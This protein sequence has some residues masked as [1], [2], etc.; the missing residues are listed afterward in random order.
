MAFGGWFGQQAAKAEDKLKGTVSDIGSTV[1]DVFIKPAVDVVQ[2]VGDLAQNTFDT[3][4]G[5]TEQLL[6]GDLGGA[7]DELKT[8]LSGIEDIVSETYMDIRDPL[9]A[10]AVMIGNYFLPGSS[11]ITSKLVSDEAQT[12]LNTNGGQLVNLAAGVGG[13]IQGN[14]SNYGNIA[15][16]TTGTP[17]LLGEAGGNTFQLGTPSE[18]VIPLGEAA[19]T[20]TAD[21]LASQTEKLLAPVRDSVPPVPSERFALEKMASATTDPIGAINAAKGYSTSDLAYL[22]EIGVPDSIIAN[23]P[24]TSAEV[25]S[26][27][28]PTA[29]AATTATSMSDKLVKGKVAGDAIAKIAS[30]AGTPTDGGGSNVAEMSALI[31]LLLARRKESEAT[32]QDPYSQVRMAAGGAVPE[33]TNT[34]TV[35]SNSAGYAVAAAPDTTGIVAPTDGVSTQATTSTTDT[36]AAGLTAKAT[37]AGATTDAVRAVD[38]AATQAAAPSAVTAGTIAASTAQG[39]VTKSLE[40]VAAEQGTVSEAAKI[41]AQTMEPTSTA[42]GNLVAAQGTAAQVAPVASRTL[43]AGELVS[44]TA[45]DQAKIDAALKQN[46]AAQGTVTEDMTTQGQLNKILTNFDAGNP[47]PWA[48]AS[49]R[50]ATA[51]MA[52]RGLGASSLAGQAII[53]ATLEAATPIAAADAKV[54]EQMGLTNLSN[55]QQ[56]AVLTGQQ[57]AA[58]L[59]QEFD[60]N[61][62]T[63]VLNAARIA[64]IADK[65]FTATVQIAL[66]N[67]QLANTMNVANLSAKNALVLAEAAQIANLE[68]TN[69]NNRQQAAVENAKSFLAMDIKNLDN[70]QQ[71]KLFKAKEIAD[72]IVSD[73]A[74]ENAA[75]ATNAANKLDA[76]KI[77]AN[78]AL[79]ASTFNAAE[80]N[81]VAITNQSAADA[82]L[83]F[84]AQEKNDRAEFNA[85]LSTQI[86]MANAK[87]LADISMSNTREQNAIAQVNA[88]NATDMSATVF[89]QKT[90]TYRDQMELAYKRSDD[91]A[92]RANEIIKQVIVS[93]ASI[94]SANQTAD[95]AFYGAIGNALTKMATG[96]GGVTGL[97]DDFKK[98]W[99]AVKGLVD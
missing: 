63:K 96:S 82:M 83:K 44:G 71:T 97:I 11:I 91:N 28:T 77:N 85:N 25:I 94:Y 99:T 16:A 13:G 4:K 86:S 57:R 14:L 48:A 62:Q 19:G 92:D 56:M 93:N 2:G 31:N 89:T 41:A 34:V 72:V 32:R 81:K 46:V 59:G 37:E 88:K 21:T 12:I 10:S 74:A 79:T 78:L 68:T 51:Q 5:T 84:N 64:D 26:A 40:Q 38:V 6:Q 73:N 36:T 30:K 15:D 75:K 17:E 80:K 87:V 66:E 1:D 27:A 60:Q 22:K 65:N 49:M 39:A 23:A 7:V 35:G 69:L 53:Q 67:A 33:V 43:Q 8:G 55:R 95:A 90:Q 58:F 52:A 54:F 45:V 20:T 18:G 42:V 3:V 61:F 9:Q 29:A 98:A 70:R 47:P 76:D 24:T 50:T